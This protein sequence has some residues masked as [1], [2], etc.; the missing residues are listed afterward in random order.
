MKRGDTFTQ[1][2]IQNAIDE[3]V[4]EMFW[5]TIR[6]SKSPIFYETYDFSTAICTPNGDIVSISIGLPLWFGV[7]K[8]LSSYMI[9]EVEKKEGI[10]LGDIIISN[11]P[12][13]TGTH[14]NDIGLAMPIFYKDDV[15]AIATTKGHVNDVG[16]MNPG[17]W[18]QL[19]QRFIKKAYSYPH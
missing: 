15:I 3:I 2:I 4:D 13:N 6:T 10:V 12:Y 5:V 9:E 14:L 17:S 1:E 16:G 7:M 19:H 18:G 8:F 11:D